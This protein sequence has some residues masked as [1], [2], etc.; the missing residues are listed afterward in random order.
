MRNSRL[1]MANEVYF[2]QDELSFFKKCVKRNSSV[3]TD[4]DLDFYLPN[5]AETCGAN[6]LQK[7]RL[8]RQFQRTLASVKSESGNRDSGNCSVR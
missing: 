8:T 3:E 6:F 1:R 7:V 5:S 4:S 2:N